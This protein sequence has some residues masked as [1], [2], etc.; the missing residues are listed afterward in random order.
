VT[1]LNE[2]TQPFRSMDG[3]E[4]NSTV[5]LAPSATAGTSTNTPL[6]FVN[7]TEAGAN[8]TAGR[9]GGEFTVDVLNNCSGLISICFGHGNVTTALTPLATPT[10]YIMNAGER[11]SFLVPPNTNYFAINPGA[12]SYTGAVAAT[13]G[14]GRA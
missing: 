13:V 14:H 3:Y 5:L 8:T 2:I 7:D 11:R 9:P 6:A 1:D 12:A 4:Y 10:S